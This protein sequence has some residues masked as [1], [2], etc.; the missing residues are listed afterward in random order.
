MI[1]IICNSLAPRA[2]SPSRAFRLEP[3]LDLLGKPYIERLAQRY[4]EVGADDVFWAGPDIP[5][6]NA[7]DGK[8]SYISLPCPDTLRNM[9]EIAL[10]ADARLWPD[11]ATCNLW[12]E[13]KHSVVDLMSF[14]IPVE[15][16]DYQEVIE[17]KGKCVIR[18]YG[19]LLAPQEHY[20][21]AAILARPERLGSMWIDLLNATIAGDAGAVR[22]LA[23][24]KQCQVLSDPV[25]TETI[26]GYLAAAH[27]LLSAGNH[28]LH[29]AQPIAD[30]VWAMP[31]AQVDPSCII[32]GPVFLGRNCRIQ[33]DSRIVGPA[34]I[35]DHAR[36][37]KKC[38]VGES[39]LM[40]RASVSHR[41]H[42][43]GTIVGTGAQLAEGEARA[44][45]WLDRAE[46]WH[47][48]SPA[49]RQ[50]F[51]SVVVP[52]WWSTWDH[53]A[54]SIGKRAM[55]LAGAI[56]GLLITLPMYPFIAVAI[57]LDSEG[58]VFF[59]DRRLT[60]G[61]KEFG[62]IKFRSMIQNAH[63]MQRK[64]RN[65][66]D[67]PQFHI[68]RDPR[69]TRLGH[70]L[71]KTKL[72]EIPQLWNVLLGQMSLVGPRPLASRET[73]LCP[74]WRESRLTV[75]PG[76]TG[77]WQTRG[78]ATRAAGDFHEWIVYDARYLHERSL[79]TDFT[80]LLKTFGMIAGRFWSQ[81]KH[82]SH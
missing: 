31:G 14:L 34:V 25:W 59:V 68:D 64:L 44:F 22:N 62:C 18:R 58:H 60:Y 15:K 29:D 26:R 70:I 61:G 24:G 11:D 20:A 16:D 63:L 81:R 74:S 67:G 54:Y 46:G 28:A 33:R 48:T 19:D 42:V 72:D 36:V 77:L 38:L 55:D 51:E 80:V 32:E 79:I 53:R 43:W 4:R 27:R 30:R 1:V 3:T 49:C 41:G 47:R 9:E 52:S 8:A 56:I 23:A 73:Q 5:G 82:N 66:V 65:E 37:G 75:R 13:D 12:E 76:M 2:A 17:P 21:P 45:G 50:R 10:V 35:G 39:V 78:T 69:I 6:P 7:D 71:R 40:P 57:K